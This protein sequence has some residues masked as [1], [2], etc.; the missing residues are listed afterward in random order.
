MG[1]ELYREV[2]VWAPESLTKG[3]KLAALVLADDA[4][5]QT[6][7]TY[8]S[9]VDPEIMRQA[10]VK[11]DRAMRRII[12]RLTDE[13]VIEKAT[14]GHN[15]RI[16]KFKFLH[17]VPA[18][19][20]MKPGENHPA[21]EA[22]DA[23]AP[24]ENHPATDGVGGWFS[25]SS[26]VKTTRPT[27]PTSST[28]SSAPPSPSDPDAP[29]PEG[30]GR[31]E[32]QRKQTRLIHA[33]AFL[34]ALPEPWTAGPK[35]ARDLAPLLLE[36]A[37]AQGWQPDD[38]LI[39][40]LTENPDGI[41]NYRAVLQTRIE[42]LPKRPTAKPA[43]TA[44]KCGECDEQGFRYRDPISETGPYRCPCRTP[45]NTQTHQGARP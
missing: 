19:A 37:T 42:D 5:D 2:K 15:G 4:N 7:L 43:A 31:D 3:E 32:Q 25:A 40:K 33:A 34:E 39:A 41:H 36:H 22:V 14:G 28:T 18:G 21:T 45:T 10:M 6:R 1:Y 26:R 29:L 16:A 35:T 17:L 9:V 23:T 44:P 11:D 27:P 30:G 20:E 24:G 38:A 13:K 8:S 12:A